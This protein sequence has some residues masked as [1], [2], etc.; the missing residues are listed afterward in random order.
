MWGLP[1]GERS[2][3]GLQ[4]NQ[5]SHHLPRRAHSRAQTCSGNSITKV[6]LPAVLSRVLGFQQIQLKTVPLYEMQDGLASRGWGD[7]RNWEWLPSGPPPIQQPA[8]IPS[9]DHLLAGTQRPPPH[10][11]CPLPSHHRPAH[12]T[13]AL[14]L[15]LLPS[16][17]EPSSA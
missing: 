8:S 1:R 12:P 13:P 17:I 10:C 5:S 4:P 2:R 11:R 9:L 6:L 15:Q 7:T 14:G 16:F 3:A